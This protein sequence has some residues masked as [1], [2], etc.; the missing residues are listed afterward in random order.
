M[1]NFFNLNKPQ[2][3]PPPP[4]HPYPICQQ[5]SVRTPCLRLDFKALGVQVVVIMHLR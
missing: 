3:T 2:P 4:P 5:S 1:A